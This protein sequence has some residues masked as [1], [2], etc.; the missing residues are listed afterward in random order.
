M[1]AISLIK[2]ALEDLK[3]HRADREENGR[4]C[5]VWEK[6]SR[7]WKVKKWYDLCVGDVISIY[8]DAYLPADILLLSTCKED[9]LCYIETMNL[10][11]ETNLKIKQAVERTKLIG[12]SDLAQFNAQ[13]EY[14]PPNAS[15]YTF[16]GNMS[17]ISGI[18][19]EEDEGPIP[20]TP[21]EV[22]LR[23]SS[24]RNTDR[25][26]GVIIYTGQ[27]TKVMMNARDPP[28]KRSNLEKKIDYLILFQFA[29]LFLFC[30]SGGIV[31]GEWH[32]KLGK[33]MWYLDLDRDPREFD[34]ND[35]GSVTGLSFVTSF[36]LYGY[37][38]PISLYVCIEIVK[39]V[40]AM[41]FIRLDRLMYYY[42]GDVAPLA[43]TSNINEE[44][45]MIDTIL[46]D[47]TGTLTRNIM[48]FFKCSVAGTAYGE[49]VTE[50]EKSNA[51]RRGE[52]VD[53]ED[54]P[55]AERFRIPGFKFY[56][57][58]LMG[59]MWRDE[60]NAFHIQ[61]FFRTLAICHT[62][63]P[64]GDSKH[65]I[66]YKAESPD[67]EALI[68]AA[69]Q[70]GFF[71][72]RRTATHIYVEERQHDG[73]ATDIEYEIMNI[74]T[75]SSDRKRMSVIYRSPSGKIF[76]ACKGADTVIM[77]R[78]NREENSHV[79]VCNDH[80]ENYG[81]SGLRTLCI[82][83][84][85]LSEHEYKEWHEEWSVANVALQNRDR[86]LANVYELIETNMTLIGCTA[87]EDQLQAGVP[88]A[89]AMLSRAGINI[90]ML[91]GD[92]METAINIGYAC[93]LLH[94]SYKQIVV[95]VDTSEIEDLER[96]GDRKEA[97][98]K[99][100][101]LCKRQVTDFVQLVRKTPPTTR[102]SLIIDGKTLSH[103]LAPEINAEFLE[104]CNSCVA[105]IACRVSPKQK[106]QI[107][108]MVKKS[109]AVTLAIGDGANDVGM[110]Q[111]AHVGVGISGQEGM[112][113]VMN[114]DFAIG[115]FCFLERL[116][117]CHGRWNYKRMGRMVAYFFYKNI[118]LGLVLF[119]YNAFTMF[120]G[121]TM[122]N[123]LYLSAWNVV[124][125]LFPSLS[126]GIFDQDIHHQVARMYP[127]VYK[128]GQN[129]E[130]FSLKV[131]SLWVA[132]AFYTGL[133]SF[134]FIML[135]SWP[136]AVGPNGQP[137]ERAAL[138]IVTYTVL[139]FV[140]TLQLGIALDHWTNYHALAMFISI[141]LWFLFLV[142][143]GN[144]PADWSEEVRL[145]FLNLVLPTSRFWLLSFVVPILCVL[146]D[147]TFRQ[148]KKFYY[149]DDHTILQEVQKVKFRER[150]LRD[151]PLVDMSTGTR[152]KGEGT[153]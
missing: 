108:E 86:Q 8:R 39:V 50:V 81:N 56:D 112:Q 9:G 75:F 70:F 141:F 119:M 3:R 71:A 54:D 7:L 77:E 35:A 151:V 102:Y 113:A 16:T 88:N 68:L 144:F 90:W 111:A 10:D 94:P 126:V 153:D 5:E 128:Q 85:E 37:L 152:K 96:A 134:L 48:E 91:T 29:L 22:V 104:L 40:Q 23:G 51:R 64:D 4:T 142:V 105:V 57:K 38:V 33:K 41:V 58:R 143:Y 121:T 83:F 30:I 17:Q 6:E 115:Q 34:P 79:K 13:L 24:L 114:S 63:I 139:L 18:D 52:E 106:A 146:P 66:N 26:I 55:I 60:P 15:L 1:L 82:A 27:D 133:V 137:I 32:A 130:Y 131:R 98:F 140:V 69:K 100:R 150:V 127:A 49:G 116:L 65:N 19:V 125:T 2:E 117:L 123:D 74:L 73:S 80:L 109:G 147:F 110:I 21:H 59:S 145:L 12:E 28:S 99:A 103:A 36:I 45:G 47:K 93:S 61:M 11:G 118:V 148:I 124:F 95:A 76:L 101:E 72:F 42:E 46:S 120:S 78:L 62:V 89:I 43:R 92:K 25:V 14:D 87:I 132:N 31:A 84:K 97:H 149:P 67:E 129:D 138:G 136:A 107:T 53:D 135:S 20:V 122:F 44:L